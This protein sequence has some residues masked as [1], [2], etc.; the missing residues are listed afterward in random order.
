MQHVVNIMGRVRSCSPLGGGDRLPRL[1]ED[2]PM[3]HVAQ[4]QATLRPDRSPLALRGFTL[5]ELLIA[6]AVAGVLAE[7]RLSVLRRPAGA[8]AARRCD[9]RRDA[10]AARAG[11]L[12]RQPH[13]LRQPR[14]HRRRRAS[15]APATTRSRSSRSGATGYELLADR[16]RHAGA[17]RGVPPPAA[18]RGRR[19]LRYASGPGRERRPTRRRSTAAA[20]ACDA[21]V[22]ARLDAA[23]TAR[24][25]TLVELLVGIGDRAADR[26]RRR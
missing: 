24:G 11:A 19:Q 10:G 2:A 13:E 17:R 7:P 15:R 26:R 18:R 4:R 8:C 23:P 12:A 25:I 9:R 22:R 21:A 1:A 6:V 3:K 14:R 5:I 20:G 16:A